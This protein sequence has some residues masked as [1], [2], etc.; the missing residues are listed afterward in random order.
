MSQPKILFCR[1]YHFIYR[2]PKTRGRMKCILSHFI[3][4]F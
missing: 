2:N 1:I 3:L 4:Y